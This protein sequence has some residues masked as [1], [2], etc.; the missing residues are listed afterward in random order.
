MRWVAFDPE[1][2]KEDVSL[3][4]EHVRLPLVQ[5]DFLIKE[6]SKDKLFV[7]NEDCRNYLQV[8]FNSP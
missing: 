6:V 1:R 8:S 7:T 2:S 3:L 4:M 5:W